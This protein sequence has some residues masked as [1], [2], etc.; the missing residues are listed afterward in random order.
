MK[1]YQH[2][3][4]SCLLAALLYPFYGAYSLLLMITGYLM[5]IDYIFIYF[6]RFGDL[7]P[8][9]AYKYLTTAQMTRKDLFLFHSIEFI[10]LLS[11][12]PYQLA[13]PLI[14]GFIVHLIL[15][16]TEELFIIK[17]RIKTFSII[18]WIIIRNK[19]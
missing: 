14:I 2:F 8:L 18:Y 13:I 1:L 10:P 6:F 11:F 3:I 15:D 16:I 7:H 5:D 9:C 17:K 4:V 19:A 12:L